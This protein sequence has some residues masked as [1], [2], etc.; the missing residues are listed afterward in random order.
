MDIKQDH[1]RAPYAEES[2]S[3]KPTLTDAEREAIEFMMR[4][5]AYAADIPSH[6]DSGDY[7]SHHVTLRGLMERTQ[8]QK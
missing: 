5:A 4:H 1:I 3:K 7:I 8:C 6:P 2:V